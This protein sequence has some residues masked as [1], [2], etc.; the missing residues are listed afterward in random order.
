MKE[1]CNRSEIDENRKNNKQFLDAICPSLS[2]QIWKYEI[3]AKIAKNSRCKFETTVNSRKSSNCRQNNVSDSDDTLHIQY[4][5]INT[6]Q[7]PCINSW[8]S[9]DQNRSINTVPTNLAMPTMETT[10]PCTVWRM[11][12]WLET[13]L[14]C[15]SH[16]FSVSQQSG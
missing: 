5:D 2:V 16:E 10:S 3:K 13:I 9:Y 12:Q 15:I 14:N 6:L 7:E 4:C 8:L 1:F 11:A